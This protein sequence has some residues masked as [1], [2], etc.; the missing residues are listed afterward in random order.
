MRINQ[1]SNIHENLTIRKVLV[2]KSGHN[3]YREG[4]E[5][6]LSESFLQES[7]HGPVNPGHLG[8]KGLAHKRYKI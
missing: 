8:Q 7:I 5:K 2:F 4:E 6:D 3:L 1:L